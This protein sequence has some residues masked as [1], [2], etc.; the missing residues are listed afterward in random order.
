MPGKLFL[1]PNL[2]APDAWH[3]LS[4]QV[5]QI[6]PGITYFLAEDL[7]NAR[8]FLSALKIMGPIENLQFELLDK[9]T[10]KKTIHTLLEPLK[11]GYDVGVLSDSGCPGVA[12]PGALAV[13]YAHQ[14][15]AEVIPL[16]GP[17]SIL[18]ALMA[19]GLNGQCFAFQGYL[20]IENE[21]RAKAIKEFE[22][23]SA[24]RKQ[25][26]LFIE[27]PYRNTTTF[28]ELVKH[29]QSSTK[30]TVA[31]TITSASQFIKTKPVS[32]WRKTSLAF[33]KEPCVFLFL[34]E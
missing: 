11:A 27:T 12:D 20:P 3:T 6:L 34:S 15:N 28:A 17:S 22:K 19:S 31:Y 32:E 23:E 18:L 16:V 4:P 29:L 24:K 30:L 9:N 8:R 21:K 13:A 2:I 7:K 1:I 10:D 5:L 26:Q 14:I 25:T 33:E